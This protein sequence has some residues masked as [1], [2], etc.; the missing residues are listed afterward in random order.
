MSACGTRSNTNTPSKAGYERRHPMHEGLGRGWA[1]EPP[2]QPRRAGV[3][4][5]R[6]PGVVPREQARARGPGQVVQ[7]VRRGGNRAK[8]GHASGQRSTGELDV[9][10]VCPSRVCARTHARNTLHAV[11]Y[12]AYCFGRC[13]YHPE[14]SASC[15]SR[16]CC[17]HTLNTLHAGRYLLLWKMSER[18]TRETSTSSV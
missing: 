12:R 15:P 18:I 1:L 9:C 11:R 8:L 16:V 4:H 2:P 7:A 10:A 14:T 17:T 13:M 6:A 5:S 3:G